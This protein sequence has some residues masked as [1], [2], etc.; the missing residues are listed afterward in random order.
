M[1]LNVKYLMKAKKLGHCPN[2]WVYIVTKDLSTWDNIESGL[3][4][5]VPTLVIGVL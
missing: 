1:A 4:F 2:C 3:N 5:L